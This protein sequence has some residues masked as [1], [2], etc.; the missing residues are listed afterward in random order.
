MWTCPECN[1]TFRNT[2]QVHTCRL[3][4]KESLLAKRS[5][6]INELYEA[7][8]H[9]LKKFGEFREEAVPPDVL[10]LKTKSTFLMVKLKTKWIDVEFFLE[11]LEDVPPVKKYLQTSKRRV[12]HVVSI[13]SLEDIDDQLIDWMH[14]SYELIANA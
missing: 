7:L 10:F 3:V 9:E 6:H 5:Q 13:D 1:R 4:T 12:V 8:L 2:N 11:K 14:R